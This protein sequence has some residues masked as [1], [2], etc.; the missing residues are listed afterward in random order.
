MGEVAPLGDGEGFMQYKKID[1]KILNIARGLRRNMTRQEKHLW[2]DFLK[3]YPI[4]IYK[5]RVIDNFIVDFYCHKAAIVI[6]VD[7]F[8]HRTYEG[9]LYDEKRTEFLE[10]YNLQV[11]RFSNED[12]D[13]RF[14]MV[15]KNIDIIIQSRISK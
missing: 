3:D 9:M 13:N 10:K 8:Q 7:G 2:Y 11:V 12:I 4:K 15:C 5:Q 1:K 6:E 14:D